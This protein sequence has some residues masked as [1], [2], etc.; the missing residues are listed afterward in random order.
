[1]NE[2]NNTNNKNKNTN[3]IYKYADNTKKKDTQNDNINDDKRWLRFHDGLLRCCKLRSPKM[4][5]VG[6]NEC[7][8][9]ATVGTVVIGK[10]VGRE[11]VGAQVDGGSRS[12]SGRSRSGSGCVWRRCRC[13]VTKTAAATVAVVCV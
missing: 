4:C 13:R 9:A 1:M 2:N 12:C 5:R 6:R 11:V 10:A 7:S 3:L 8:V